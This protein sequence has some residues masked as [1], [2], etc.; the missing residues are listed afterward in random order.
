MLGGS[1]SAKQQVDQLFI[2]ATI[3]V[4][5]RGTPSGKQTSQSSCVQVCA[6]AN[7]IMY[8]MDFIIVARI[9]REV[10]SNWSSY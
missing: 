4:L 3:C 8:W 9:N 2:E 6:L 1:P 7:L 5:R 10:K